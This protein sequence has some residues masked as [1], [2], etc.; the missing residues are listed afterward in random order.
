[1]SPSGLFHSSSRSVAP[2][3]CKRKFDFVSLPCRLVVRENS[4]ISCRA[5]GSHCILKNFLLLL[6]GE[7][8][9]LMILQSELWRRQSNLEQVK[10]ISC[11]RAQE[12]LFFIASF[13]SKSFDIAIWKWSFSNW[14]LVYGSR[15]TSSKP[16]PWHYHRCFIKNSTSHPKVLYASLISRY[17]NHWLVESSPWH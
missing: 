11:W 13:S 12:L 7:W 8:L 10:I 2:G 3:K 6:V 16:D 17:W 9:V 4:A 15:A 5:E 1:M 14:S